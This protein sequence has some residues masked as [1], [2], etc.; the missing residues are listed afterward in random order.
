MM[1]WGNAKTTTRICR[2]CI[3]SWTEPLRI[4]SPGWVR[5]ITWRVGW[6]FPLGDKNIAIFVV[7]LF[8]KRPK[9]RSHVLT[10]L[11]TYWGWVMGM[12]G[13]KISLLIP[14]THELFWRFIDTKRTQGFWENMALLPYSLLHNTFYFLWLG[15]GQHLVTSCSYYPPKD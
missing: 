8:E 2:P 10:G 1:P 14:V 7:N 3:N 6:S 5:S 11:M 4:W 9:T 15:M 12:S 13:S